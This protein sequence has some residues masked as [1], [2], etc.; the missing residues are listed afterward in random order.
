MVLAKAFRRVVLTVASIAQLV[1]G[2]L[3]IRFVVKLQ[4]VDVDQEDRS[5]EVS[6]AL[7][8]HS[9]EPGE[10]DKSLCILAYAGVALSFALMLALSIILA[11][12]SL[13]LS[14]CYC[15][16]SEVQRK[17]SCACSH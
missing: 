7:D 17:R 13:S 1:V 6:C 12:L 3:I 15:S 16:C 11:C 2:I 4:D 5:V 10:E 9:N 8:H 14:L